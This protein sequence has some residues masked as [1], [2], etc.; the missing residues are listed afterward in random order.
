MRIHI[1]GTY[2]ARSHPRVAVLIEGLHAIG[3]DVTEVNRP[4]GLDTAARVAIL[5]Q[6]WRLPLF[7][8]RLLACWIGLAW[9]SIRARG[10]GPPDAVLVGYLGHFDVHLARI[11]YPRSTIVLDH[12]VSAA[13]VAA[14]RRLASS[15]DLKYRL[16]KLIDK[17]AVSSADIVIVDTEEHQDALPQRAR[18]RSVV[19][20]VG[21]TQEWLDAGSRALGHA[22]GDP[23]RVIFVGLFSPAH[24]T[25]VI[26]E[27]LDMLR[28]DERIEVTMV[29]RGQEYAD[30]R[31]V[32]A[33]NPHITWIDWISAEDLPTF[34]SG[35]D[36]SL[37]L[38][39]TVP[40]ALNVVPTK[41][42]QGAAAGCVVLTSDT[43]PQRRALEGSSMLV[44]PGTATELAAALRKLAGDPD[45]TQHLRCA[46]HDL[47]SELY[48]PSAVVAPLLT[49]IDPAA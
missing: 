22:T 45:E 20:P 9:G 34:V 21:A 43:A 23:L 5:R 3:A 15:G 4:L 1:F 2:D 19:C 39:G 12:M 25:P 42:F 30:A 36:V 46:A 37:G 35:F 24:G 11:L 14:N 6:P 40:Q 44:T 26:A 16:M 31:R 13:G 18:D 29:G 7:A 41:A 27:A 38:F 8:F 10:E 33:P 17:A 47:A 49:R 28:D 48:S 32:A